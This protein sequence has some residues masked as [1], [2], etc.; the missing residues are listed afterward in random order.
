MPIAMTPLRWL[1]A[2]AYGV[3]AVASFFYWQEIDTFFDFFLGNSIRFLTAA[4]AILVAIVT[5]KL[6]VAFTAILAALVIVV[7]VFVGIL[8][9]AFLPG[10]LKAIALPLVFDFLSFI[11]K[12]SQK[13]QQFVTW[14]LN[15]SKG[16]YAN[17]RG[18]WQAQH[19][20]DKSLMATLAFL[21][22]PILGL[23][24]FYKRFILP[25]LI[26]KLGENFVQRGVKLLWAQLMKTPL[27]GNLLHFVRMS[28]VL[29]KRYVRKQNRRLIHLRKS[30]AKK[31][32]G[33]DNDR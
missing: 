13:L 28:F 30:V 24:F 21:T 20:V 3:V 5:L 11:H 14:L 23:V 6:G 25:F 15:W 27:V 10:T 33:H 31:P 8:I 4:G 12:K 19:I 17:T 29:S 32:A 7:K 1:I 22:V 26:T 2:I 18:W 16:Q 9:T